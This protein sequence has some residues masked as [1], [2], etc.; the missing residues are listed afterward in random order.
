MTRRPTETFTVKLHMTS[1]EK[2]VHL[3][4]RDADFRLA[5]GRGTACGPYVCDFPWAGD[6]KRGDRWTCPRCFTTYKLT[7]PRPLRWYRRYWSAPHGFWK[8]WKEARR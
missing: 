6:H 1:G 5:S 8:E 2:H 3:V 7:G 4:D